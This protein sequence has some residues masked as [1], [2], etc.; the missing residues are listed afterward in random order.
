MARLG[1]FMNPLDVANMVWAFST[2]KMEEGGGGGDA[3][4]AAALE[5]L[6]AAEVRLAPLMN[7]QD[8]S[9]TMLAGLY[10]HNPL[11]P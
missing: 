1:P 5:A 3:S 8:V 11:Y 4:L 6:E 7:A 9:N 2:L 10:K